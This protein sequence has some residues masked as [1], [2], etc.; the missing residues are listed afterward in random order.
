MSA[1]MINVSK[2]GMGTLERRLYGARADMLQGRE[3]DRGT[4][5][6]RETRGKEGK[7]SNSKPG[8]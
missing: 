7:G 4:E 6:E 5:R 3:I 8:R 2:C 1:I